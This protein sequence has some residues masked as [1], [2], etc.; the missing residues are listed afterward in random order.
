MRSSNSSSNN[1]TSGTG[2]KDGQSLVASELGQQLVGGLVEVGQV[3]R[4]RRNI[5]EVQ[6]VSRGN[7]SS[8]VCYYFLHVLGNEEEKEGAV[9]V[10]LVHIDRSDCDRV[11][12]MQSSSG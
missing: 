5:E 12:K 3:K 7:S 1:K 6:E 10:R 4:D 8:C 11:H 2:I 9:V